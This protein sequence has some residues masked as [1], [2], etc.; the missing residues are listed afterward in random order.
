MGVATKMSDGYG[1]QLFSFYD[2]EHSK[3]IKLDKNGN[4]T[5][6]FD[7]DSDQSYYYITDMLELDGKLYLSTYM[8]P[9]RTGITTNTRYEIHDI[10]D[11]I[12]S[13]E[14]WGITSEELTPLV[15]ENYT[16]VLL[17]CDP[18]SGTPQEFYSVDGSLG[19][20][21]G[22]SD[23][24]HLTWDVERI[25]TAY[26]SLAT[27]AFTIAGGCAVYQSTFCDGTVTQLITGETTGFYR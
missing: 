27:S 23:A 2:N 12:F 6:T 14:R 10:L 11:Y 21:L 4:I 15:Q 3:I 20:K 17:V 26:F 7:Y 25:T 19:G 22:I 18:A 16:A 5:A 8:T 13:E 1:V 24:G 9:K